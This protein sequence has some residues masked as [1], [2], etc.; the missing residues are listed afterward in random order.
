MVKIVKTNWH[1]LSKIVNEWQGHLLSCQVTAKNIR[2]TN[3][4]SLP[5]NLDL[6]RPKYGGCT[7]AGRFFFY[8]HFVQS[9][10]T[11]FDL[12]FLVMEMSESD[13]AVEAITV[14]LS[15][16]HGIHLEIE[17]C[18]MTFGN[19]LQR[20]FVLISKDL[21]PTSAAYFFKTAC[22]AIFIVGVS[23]RPS[24]LKSTW[25]AVNIRS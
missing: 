12:S 15:A 1:K 18:K 5:I 3:Q 21:E 20:I 6:P 2:N 22:R 4:L 10:P 25:S 7:D 24:V 16:V 23:S 11:N 13:T 14:E 9:F 17:L 8:S 19:W